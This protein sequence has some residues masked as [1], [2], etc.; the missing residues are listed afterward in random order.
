MKIGTN[1]TNVEIV[2]VF[3]IF[4]CLIGDGIEFTRLSILLILK[5]LVG[6]G[7]LFTG[8]EYLKGIQY[9]PL[10]LHVEASCNL[11]NLMIYLARIVKKNWLNYLR[12]LEMVQ[13]TN[14]LCLW[15]SCRESVVLNFEIEIFR[16]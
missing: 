9:L 3:F 1:W 15:S 14:H 16:I 7:D 5:L 13:M 6:L 10:D 2:F 11:I 8:L 12:E 4:E